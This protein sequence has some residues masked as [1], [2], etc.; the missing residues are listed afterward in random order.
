MHS[1]N[2]LQFLCDGGSTF[3]SFLFHLRILKYMKFYIYR[4]PKTMRKKR[5]SQSSNPVLPPEV[6]ITEDVIIQ[7]LMY[8]KMGNK[9]GQV[10][11]F[12]SSDL[13]WFFKCFSNAL[14]FYIRMLVIQTICVCLIV[15]ILSLTCFLWLL[16]YSKTWQSFEIAFNFKGS[17]QCY[18]LF[19]VVYSH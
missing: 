5:S 6:K 17:V 8:R 13:D 14:I 1:L 3:L 4:M 9:P 7:A 18:Y 19:K 15:Y 16:C 10:T 12:K 2:L 11:H